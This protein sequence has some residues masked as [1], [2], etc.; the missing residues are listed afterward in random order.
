M[1]NEPWTYKIY[2]MYRSAGD[3]SQVP[4]FTLQNYQFGP[5][6]YANE[7]SGTYKTIGH[8][9]ELYILDYFTKI[10]LGFTKPGFY[11]MGLE[12]ESLNSIRIPLTI[13]NYPVLGI[14]EHAFLLNKDFEISIEDREQRR[15]NIMPYAFSK[16]E[17][18][19]PTLKITGE[20]G[21]DKDSMGDYK[22]CHTM[23][24][25]LAFE[26]LNLILEKQIYC[27]LDLAFYNC[28]ILKLE[29]KYEC[30]QCCGF[31]QHPYAMYFEFNS[32]YLTNYNMFYY[33]LGHPILNPIFYNTKIK[34]LDCRGLE[35]YTNDE[36]IYFKCY[37]FHSPLPYLEHWYNEAVSRLSKKSEILMS[38]FPTENIY[39]SYYYLLNYI[40]ID[41]TY[42]YNYLK[43][44]VGNVDLYKNAK[45]IV[46]TSIKF[47][48]H[49][50]GILN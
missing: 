6:F 50:I 43:T 22:Y 25:P 45:N 9:F 44:F 4:T 7:N 39:I 17:N 18:T 23:I 30:I 13:K 35:H 19:N 47:I 3:S 36:N 48:Y 12:D 1:L 38:N 34:E 11:V 46:I 33:P 40:E 31:Y 14:G 49:K 29:G 32:P 42:N 41:D 5:H 10:D 20:S 27:C 37:T 21:I 28:N 15:F 16:T 2:E 8:D 24:F 26:N